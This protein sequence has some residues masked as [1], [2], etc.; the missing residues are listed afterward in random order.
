VTR[1]SATQI[2]AFVR[3]QKN[4]EAPLED[5]IA[6][7]R[8]ETPPTQAM[9][10]GTAFHKVLERSTYCEIERIEQDGFTFDFSEMDCTLELPE[11][12]EIKLERVIP[13]DGEQVTV[14]GV[15]DAQKANGAYD[16][17]LTARFDAERYAD[18]YQWRCYLHWFDLDWFTYNVFE[19]FQPANEPGLY[20]VRQF[21]PLTFTRYPEIG[22][23]VDRLS[24]E[25]VRFLREYLPE[26]AQ[27]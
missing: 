20:M 22:A 11:V 2:D 27:A 21:H 14:V 17:K 19:A 7:L 8:K 5:F 6:Y 10:A 15:L 1:I 24:A 16:H 9:Q 13:I 18:S 23:D 25:F 4:E 26:M 3:W 12:R